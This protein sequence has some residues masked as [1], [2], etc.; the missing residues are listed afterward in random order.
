MFKTFL[1]YS[2]FRRPWYV[3][4]L[5]IKRLILFNFIPILIK[6]TSKY[7]ICQ[8][9]EHLKYVLYQHWLPL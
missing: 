4:F 1:E 2:K 8:N 9:L 3:F 6:S 7:M 5:I